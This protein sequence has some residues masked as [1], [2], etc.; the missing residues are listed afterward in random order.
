MNVYLSKKLRVISLLLII[1]IVFVHSYS[2]NFKQTGVLNGF[3]PFLQYFISQ[4][5][6]RLPTPVF[7]TIS[8]YLFFLNMKG[9]WNEYGSKIKKRFRTVAVP[10][11]FWSAFGLLVYFILQLS[12]E[13]RVFFQ[14]R[15]VINYSITEILHAIFINPV[16]GQLW[17]LRD[18][19]VL[20]IL[21]PIIFNLVKYLKFYIVIL[22]LFLWFY[23][24]DFVI[25]SNRG[26]FFFTLGVYLSTKQTLLMMQDKVS[27][28]S[29]FF[30][31]LWIC[32]FLFKTFLIYFNYIDWAI[33]G[34]IHKIGILLGIWAVWSFYDYLSQN[35]NLQVNYLNKLL[36][37]T[38]F[39]YVFHEPVLTML[40]KLLEHFLGKGEVISFSLYLGTPVLVILISVIVAKYTKLFIP[41]FYGIITGSR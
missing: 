18:L 16:P 7:F 34:I 33:L 41:K 25:V 20:V 38:F 35:E 39:I 29:L 40:R 17:Y 5:L 28:S 37:F 31:F 10:Y 4:G 36:P 15:I 30:I 24:F 9:T 19:F 27:K 3:F 6:F 23:D 22:F 12:P 32:I 11:I 26:M 1:M 14:K 2:L 8:G 13:L 21:S